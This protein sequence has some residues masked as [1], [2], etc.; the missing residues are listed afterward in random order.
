MHVTLNVTT[1][2]TS[3]GSLLRMD[4]ELAIGSRAQTLVGRGYV[5]NLKVGTGRFGHGMSYNH[6]PAVSRL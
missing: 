4:A 5:M 2:L 3:G 1:N 6:F